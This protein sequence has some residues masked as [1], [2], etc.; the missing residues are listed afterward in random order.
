MKQ[1]S[2]EIV[3]L[4]SVLEIKLNAKVNLTKKNLLAMI[5]STFVFGV[6]AAGII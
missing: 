2:P 6:E 1:K 4:L 3:S 5:N